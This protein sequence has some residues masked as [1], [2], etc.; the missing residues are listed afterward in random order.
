MLHVCTPQGSKS[1]VAEFMGNPV[2]CYVYQLKQ[3]FNMD[4]PVLPDD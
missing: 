4:V 3:A 1:F 2:M